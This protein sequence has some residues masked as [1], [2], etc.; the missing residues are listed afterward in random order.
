MAIYSTSIAELTRRVASKTSGKKHNKPKANEETA[1]ERTNRLARERR[2]RKKQEELDHA[3]GV[4]LA[5]GKVDMPVRDE[6]DLVHVQPKEKAAV[7][8][9]SPSAPATPQTKKKGKQPAAAPAPDESE[10]AASKE[11]Q[12]PDDAG[13]DQPEEEEQDSTDT[14]EE[15][16]DAN[17]E[18]PPVKK[19]RRRTQS[20]SSSSF[21]DTPPKWYTKLLTEVIKTKMTEAGEKASAKAIKETGD[22]MAKERWADPEE[23]AKMRASQDKLYSQ[24][25]RY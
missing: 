9:P 3:A 18:K 1:R 19:K 15:Q 2:A 6:S 22:E 7:P 23:Q 14:E 5:T 13:V 24:I 8:R 4:T 11:N 21:P 12:E 20:R 17:I 10:D 25:F 16:D